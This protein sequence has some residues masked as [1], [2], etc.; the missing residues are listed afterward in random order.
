[1]EKG[2]VIS[3]ERFHSFLVRRLLY[4]IQETDNYMKVNYNPRKYS[5]LE[6]KRVYLNV[7]M[8]EIHPYI[9][10]FQGIPHD[11]IYAEIR[12]TLEEELRDKMKE[13]YEEHYLRESVDIGI[14][15][16]GDEIFALARTTYPYLYPC[17]YNRE[18][19][20]DAILKDVHDVVTDDYLSLDNVSGYREFLKVVHGDHFLFHWDYNCKDQI[21]ESDNVKDKD[22]K[23]GD[24]ML[25]QSYDRGLTQVLNSDVLKKIYPM[26]ER[27]EVFYFESFN[28][29]FVRIYVNDPEMNGDN[30]YKKGLD[31][32]YLIDNHLMKFLPYF[33]YDSEMGR[34]GFIIYGPNKNIISRWMS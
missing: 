21:N 33:G 19:Y 10:S 2:Y 32:H 9:Y 31:P 15:R 26:I 29:M 13:T 27:A 24:K 18:D 14:K 16:R 4:L 30:M 7:L 22:Y 8:D 23:F 1:M 11:K 6:W 12:E 20:V 28:R 34:T 3:D 5:Y 25:D 17:D